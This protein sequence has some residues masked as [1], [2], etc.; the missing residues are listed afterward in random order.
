M[1]FY[2]QCKPPWLSSP[3]NFSLPS[4]GCRAPSPPLAS[5]CS[6]T[7]PI[8]PCAGRLSFLPSRRRRLRYCRA[9]RVAAS[10]VL[11]ASPPLT[12][13]CDHSP[14]PPW[15]WPALS[16]PETI[17]IAASAPTSGPSVRGR[18]TPWSS[19]D[20]PRR[21]SAA[22]APVSTPAGVGLGNIV[23]KSNKDFS[24]FVK[25]HIIF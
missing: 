6:V 21:L 2:R 17:L 11:L 4:S 19:P 23:N 9:S 5:R 3:P 12:C 18:W 24:L 25:A 10:A 1:P 13:A 7:P 20:W 8:R 15:P 16:W 22:W 14:P